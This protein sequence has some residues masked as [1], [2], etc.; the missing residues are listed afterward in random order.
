MLWS[1]DK[2]TEVEYGLFKVLK[3]H[4]KKKSPNWV[5]IFSSPA[6]A[7]TEVSLVFGVPAPL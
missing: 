1:L 3:I 4:I 2:T 5:R 6:S 7:E